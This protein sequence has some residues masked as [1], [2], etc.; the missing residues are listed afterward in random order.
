MK[1]C[2][3]LPHFYPYIGG[4]EKLFYDFAR[5]LQERGHEIRVVARNV[6]ADYLGHKKLDGLDVYYCPWK[7]MFGHP[8]LRRADVEE[9]VKWCDVVHTSI[10]TPAALVSRLARKYKKPSVMTVHEVRGNKWFWVEGILK[11]TLFFVYEQYVCRQPYDVYHAVSEATKRDYLTFCGK[12]N[13]VRVYNAVSEM[14]LSVADRADIDLHEY[15]NITK[16]DRVFLYY[17]R[18]GQTKGIHVYREALKQIREKYDKEQLAHIKFCFILGAEPVKLRRKFIDSVKKYGLEDIVIIRDSVSRE[19]LCKCILQADY[20]VVP[21]VT[22]GFGLSALE[23]C[24]MGK[25]IIYSD[26]GALPEVVYGDCL[27]F[28]NCNS[29]Q[30]AERLGAVIEKGDAAFSHVPE[31]TFPYEDMIDG[32]ENIYKT[33]L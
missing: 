31:R 13:V 16:E 21:S 27:S 7:S 24:L 10:F 20:V 18:P 2:F 30:L 6:G 28:E 25:K 23:A 22:E 14:D 15:F 17:G 11:A 12:K 32:I 26:G 1:I 3:V 29:T 33:L 5:G 9:H 19:N 4:G 8:L